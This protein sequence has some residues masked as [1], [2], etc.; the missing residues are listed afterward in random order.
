MLS[1]RLLRH[2]LD[3]TSIDRILFSTDYPFQHVAAPAVQRFLTCVPR[4]PDREKLAFRNAERL[5]QIS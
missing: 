2:A 1:D 3:F 5:L 4:P